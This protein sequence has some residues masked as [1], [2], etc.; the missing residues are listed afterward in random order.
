M[1]TENIDKGREGDLSPHR[2][3]EE[4]PWGSW[5]VLVDDESYKVKRLTVKVGERLSYQKHLKRQEHWF[6][7]KG[8]AEVTL[9]DHVHILKRGDS[10]NIPVEAKHRIRNCSASE[11]LV[12][13]EVQTGTYFGEDDIVRYSDDYGRA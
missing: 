8:E 2:K 11:T 4:T 9:N 6:V 7:V 13:I 5:E 3:Y 1:L 12:F 10:I